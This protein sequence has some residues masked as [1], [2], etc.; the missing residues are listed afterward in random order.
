M[1]AIVKVLVPVAL[2]FGAF[3]AQAAGTIETD[4]PMNLQSS[5]SAAPGAPSQG[6]S[7]LVQSNHEGITE[8]GTAR[9]APAIK[10]D[11]PAKR[12]SVGGSVMEK[13][14][15]DLGYFA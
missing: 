2:A 9:V 13:G 1:K 4:Y 3:G 8:N 7:F 5:A 10:A 15:T 11:V 14:A 12:G 6:E